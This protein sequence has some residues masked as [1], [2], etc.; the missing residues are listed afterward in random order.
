MLKKLFINLVFIALLTNFFTS[1]ASSEEKIYIS[2]VPFHAPE[3]IWHLYSPLVSYLNKNT[4][5]KWELKLYPNHDAIKDALCS[6]ELS[7]ALFGPI[8]AY[9]AYQECGASPL[10]AA[11]NDNGK[12]NFKV[13]IVS[14]DQKIR[15]LK[16]L[17]GHKVGL[18]KPKTVA[19]WA[20]KKML[21]D[22]G[23]NEGNVEFIVFQSLE[24]ISNEILTGSIKAGGIRETNLKTFKNFNLNILK[25]SDPLPG[26]IFMAS[27]KVSDDVRKKF[28][29][30][31][32][33]LNPLK[34]KTDMSTVKEW[35]EVI[36]YGFSLPPKDYMQEVEKFYM[37]Y[38]KYTQ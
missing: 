9:K 32:L 2:V 31:L 30:A 27:P 18:F 26:F 28:T 7:I 14:V 21:A 6:N 38:N 35:D 24:R 3:K 36:K 1:N 33:K 5:I 4:D 20:T 10:I 37:L 16:D 15:S 17:K 13:A 29:N 23:L 22:E 34:N 8:L 11:L 25:I 19:N 12:V